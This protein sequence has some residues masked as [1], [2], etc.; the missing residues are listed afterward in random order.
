MSKRKLI[1]FKLVNE[2]R[3]ADTIDGP[4]RRSVNSPELREKINQSDMSS[5]LNGGHLDLSPK[6]HH[7]IN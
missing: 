2:F 6:V 7:T 1:L 4:T 3:E 5:R